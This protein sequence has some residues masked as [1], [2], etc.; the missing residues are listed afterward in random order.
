MCHPPARTGALGQLV[1]PYGSVG[2][3]QDE[4]AAA[5]LFRRL[6]AGPHSPFRGGGG[7]PK[8]Q[9]TP[10]PPNVVPA[11]GVAAREG[12]LRTGPRRR[13]NPAALAGVDALL[14]SSRRTM[15]GRLGR[16]KH[17]NVIRAAKRAGG[18]GGGWVGWWC[19]GPV[20]H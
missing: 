14:H 12:R 3:A 17:R 13:A 8:N 16:S 20:L 9:Q 4:G 11:W 10:P 1:P 6:G 2:E 15:W 7:L 19:G 18:G 5:E